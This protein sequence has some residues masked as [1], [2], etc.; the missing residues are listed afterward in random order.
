[1]PPDI[2]ERDTHIGKRAHHRSKHTAITPH[3]Q[4]VII[5]LEIDEKFGSLEIS[6]CNA[7]IILSFWV[8]EFCQAPIDEPQLNIGLVSGNVFGFV[9]HFA[10]FMI[11]HDIMWLYI[12]MHDTLGVAK[13]QCLLVTF[14]H[15][16][17][18]EG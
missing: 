3:I 15:F 9:T 10:V 1:M 18:S 16:G 17:Q 8:I 13:I 6:R 4:T 11:Y 2:N 5:F 14:S 7:D 12:P